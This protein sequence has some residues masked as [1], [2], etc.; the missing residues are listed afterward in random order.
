MRTSEI[1]IRPMISEKINRQMEK[2]GRYTFQV[3]HAANKLEI[4]NEKK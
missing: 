1:L 4:K 3:G 2:D